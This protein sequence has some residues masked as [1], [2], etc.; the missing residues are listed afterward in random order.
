MQFICWVYIGATWKG[1]RIYHVCSPAF[2]IDQV[3]CLCDNNEET[4]LILKAPQ[5]ILNVLHQNVEHIYN[6]IT[7]NILP[8]IKPTRNIRFDVL[9]Q[10]PHAWCERN[11]LKLRARFSDRSVANL[12]VWNILSHK[13]YRKL[14]KQ[15]KV[16]KLSFLHV[17]KLSKRLAGRITKK[18]PTLPVQSHVAASA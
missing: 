4:Q 9:P 1:L 5:L 8:V 3:Q 15:Q 16:R 12:F 14:K 13:A 11:K 6:F 18:H 17:E 2:L 7:K 10:A